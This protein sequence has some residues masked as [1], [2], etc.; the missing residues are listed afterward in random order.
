MYSPIRVQG[1]NCDLSWIITNE[2]ISGLFVIIDSGAEEIILKD[3]HK[4][5]ALTQTL[6]D[7]EHVTSKWV[8]LTSLHYIDIHLVAVPSR[9]NE[10]EST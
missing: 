5:S 2:S 9:H 8:L 10:T 4:K 6:L 1:T 3:K 7:D